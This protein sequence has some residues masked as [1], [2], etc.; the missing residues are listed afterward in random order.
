MIFGNFIAL[1]VQRHRSPPFRTIC[2]RHPDEPRRECR[3]PEFCIVFAYVTLVLSCAVASGAP[4]H[5]GS[6][7]GL[8]WFMRA[9]QMTEDGRLTFLHQAW[10]PR[11]QALN[12]GESFTL[13]LNR[14]GRQDTLIKRLDGNILE[15]I[16][17][18]GSAKEIWNQTSTAYVVSYKG[19]GLV[20]R[21]VAYNDRLH[22]GKASE[23]EI[24][25]YKDGYLRY[26]WFGENYDGDGA[27]IFHLTNW[28]Y[29]GNQLASKFRGNVMIYVNKYD[30]TTRS[31]TPLSECPFTFYDPNRDG[32]GEV[33]VRAAVQTRE[34]AKKSDMDHANSYSPMWQPEPLQLKDMVV[35]N[36]RL[37]YNIDVEPRKA[38]VTQPHY[39]FGF[40]MTGD[41]AYSFVGMKY[42]NL[43]RRPPQTVVRVPWKMA[44]SEARHYLAHQ[45]G[46]SWDEARDVHRWEGEFWI[47]ERRILANTGGPT[48]RW[49]MRR[50]FLD[51]PSS[52]RELYYSD[53]DKR[54]HLFG[55]S[56]MWME[57][58]NVVGNQKDLEVRAYDSDHD[59]FLDTWEIFDPTQAAPV[60]VTRVLDPRARMIR[61]D[62]QTMTREYNE[63]ILP[64]AIAEDRALL[65]AMKKFIKS[66]S[67]DR[68]EAAA[69]A[70]SDPE[71]VRY[72]LDV[73]RELYFLKTRDYF[74]LL[75]TQGKYPA[76]MLA[77]PSQTPSQTTPEGRYS[78]QDT[79]K[80]WTLAASIESFVNAYGEGKFAAAANLLATMP[81]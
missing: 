41:E 11:A 29:D 16:D 35:A 1:F 36:M 31:W 51:K 5:N 4:P 6:H 55:A 28:Q 57:V 80:F 14:D 26:G 47:Y 53:I 59:G 67:G 44:E 40:T 30:P 79:E 15:A 33:V 66:E 8:P 58:G 72:C 19:T 52:S 9:T 2:E 62:R 76:G 77:A 37:S 18:S 49:N 27:Q 24:R 20:D 22:T 50:E 46:F 61:L 32:L 70:A 74:Y 38:T 56:E 13:D 34:Q 68:Y 39:N 7:M 73:A 23:M 25:Y 65:V 12:E 64:E 78:V 71:R 10:W 43:S 45:T 75:D 69:A 48:Q 60:R 81:R 3:L 42:T 63:H 17:D 54:Y 21:M